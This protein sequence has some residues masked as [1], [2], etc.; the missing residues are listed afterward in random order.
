MSATTGVVVAEAIDQLVPQRIELGN[1]ER[2]AK[3]N[4][5]VVNNQISAVEIREV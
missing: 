4:P 3:W 1:Q 5:D 2:L